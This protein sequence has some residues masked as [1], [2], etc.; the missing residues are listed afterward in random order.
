M[1]MER[2]YFVAADNLDQQ[3]EMKLILEVMEVDQA[4]V[5]DWKLC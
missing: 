4:L 5:A 3:I 2:H 1:M